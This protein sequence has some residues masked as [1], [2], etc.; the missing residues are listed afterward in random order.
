[1]YYCSS[2]YFFSV[3]RVPLHPRALAREGPSLL[4]SK[5]LSPSWGC[6]SVLASDSQRTCS[7]ILRFIPSFPRKRIAKVR[8]FW[9]MAIK[10]FNYFQSNV[11][12]CCKS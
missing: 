2:I 3:S 12:Y 10:N 7:L 1:L 8:P 4:P 9:L 6:G 5:P 11:I